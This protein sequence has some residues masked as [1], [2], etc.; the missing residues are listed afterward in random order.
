[1]ACQA[2]G[3]AGSSDKDDINQWVRSNLKM[4]NFKFQ[5]INRKY[6]RILDSTFKSN[7]TEPTIT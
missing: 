1:V 7:T 2:A 5:A 4:E 3:Q 6:L